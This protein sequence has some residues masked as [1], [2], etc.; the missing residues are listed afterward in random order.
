MHGPRRVAA[1]LRFLEQTPSRDFFH[2]RYDPGMIIEE[3]GHASDHAV[4]VLKGTVTIGDVECVEGTLVV[5]EQGAAFGPLIAGA[6]G[7][8]LLEFYAGDPTPV[9][10]N[11]GKFAALLEQRGV[12]A[13]SPTFRP[14]PPDATSDPALEPEVP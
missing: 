4:F 3:H 8:E 10:T 14:D 2:C 13:A 6:E 11:P 7:T 9:P 12:M 1:H 5:L